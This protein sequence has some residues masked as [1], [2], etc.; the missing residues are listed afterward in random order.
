MLPPAFGCVRS[1]TQD[2]CHVRRVPL[3][4]PL[5]FVHRVSSVSLLASPLSQPAP[6]ALFE[7]DVS[8]GID[9]DD[10]FEAFVRGS[11]SMRPL[12]HPGQNN[13]TVSERGRGIA[14][15]A[16]GSGRKART[17][18]AWYGNDGSVG[19]RSPDMKAQ[20]ISRTVGVSL[21]ARTGV[22]AP[23][24]HH[25]SPR[26]KK[27][28]ETPAT[29]SPCATTVAH[30]ANYLAPAVSRTGVSPRSV[31]TMPG[32][33][34]PGR[35]QYCTRATNAG[36][37]HEVE[38]SPV[39]PLTAARRDADDICKEGS[40]NRVGAT[41][42]HAKERRGVGGAHHRRR[43]ATHQ[44]RWVPGDEELG[45]GSSSHKSRQKRVPQRRTHHEREPGRGQTEE[46]KGYR[47]EPAA[48]EFEQQQVGTDGFGVTAIPVAAA[49]L[50]V[51]QRHQPP[52][53]IATERVNKVHHD[54]ESNEGVDQNPKNSR[55]PSTI[56][57]ENRAGKSDALVHGRGCHGSGISFDRSAAAVR[58]Q[59]VFRGHKGRRC[60]GA[61]GRKRASQRA[62]EREARMER[63]RP[64]AV[65]HRLS[66]RLP[67]PK[68]P[69]TYGF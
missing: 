40:S 41:K 1:K 26:G 8:T 5:Q 13:D 2:G 3:A 63:E 61:E 34:L 42:S 62:S 11:W 69:S 33:R 16:G 51:R 57:D 53:G 39:R 12:A 60:A 66:G 36:S 25:R 6:S 4:G 32:A 21:S 54:F 67:R 20:P 50:S 44:A 18:P 37:V 38:G 49:D 23:G 24:L 9:G 19:N 59:R 45:D 55:V 14:A 64:H 27:T 68:L 48:Y 7:R 65:S 28:G 35:N 46:L 52:V 30:R 47:V 17:A 58:V 31:S 29:G 10:A 56:N 15:G 43:P 22:T